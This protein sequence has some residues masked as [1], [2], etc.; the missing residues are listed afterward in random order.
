MT[1][2]PNHLHYEIAKK[3]LENGKHVIVEKPFTPTYRQAKA[4]ID[5]ANFF[6]KYMK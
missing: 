5:L 6:Y 2:T 1:T 4:L 3:A